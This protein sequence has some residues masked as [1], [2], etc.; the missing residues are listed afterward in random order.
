[1][2]VE[3]QKKYGMLSIPAFWREKYKGQ[4]FKAILHAEF[5]ASVGLWGPHFLRG[6]SGPPPQEEE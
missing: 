5:E 1:M 2:A 6:K 4:E 3:L